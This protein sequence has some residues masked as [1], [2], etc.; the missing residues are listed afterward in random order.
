MMTTMITG[1]EPAMNSHARCIASIALMYWAFML[2]PWRS[3]R[4]RPVPRGSPPALF[5]ER[6]NSL[7]VLNALDQRRVLGAVLVPHRLHGR[8]ELLLV[9]NVVDLDSC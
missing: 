5:R 9:G 4:G 6:P 7:H 2:S 8:L 1:T 3:E